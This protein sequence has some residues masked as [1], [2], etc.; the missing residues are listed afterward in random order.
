MATHTAR[1]LP[2]VTDRDI[3]DALLRHD[4][5]LTRDFFYRRCYPLFK[6]VFDNYCT[7]SETCQEF[8]SEIYL[9]IM[10][11]NRQRPLQAAGIRVPQYTLHLAQ[12]G[13]P[14]LLLQ[15]VRAKG[16]DASGAYC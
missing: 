4:E 16:K 15:K 9:H 12:N 3:V 8:I 1:P 11:P 5:V 14:L 13:V 2:A 6:S 10:Q 7:D